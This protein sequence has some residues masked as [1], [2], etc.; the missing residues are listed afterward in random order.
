MNYRK[1]SYTI[2]VCVD[3]KDKQYMLIH[4]YTGAI[5]LVSEQLLI[6]LNSFSNENEF[7]PD[8]F[9]TLLKRGYLTEKTEDEERDYLKRMAMALFKRDTF[10]RKG[11]TFLVTYNCNFCCPYC[12]EKEIANEKAVFTKEMV[13]KAYHAIMQI[14]SEEK[15][16]SKGITLYGGEPLL[17]SNKKIVSYIIERGKEFGFTFSAI[18]N[19][20]DL[21]YYED[22]LSEDAIRFLQIT[23]DGIKERHNGRRV[24]RDGFS[25]FDKIVNNIGIALNKGVRVSV[26]VNTDRNNVNDLEELQALFTKMNYM[27]NELFSINTAL[28]KNYSKDTVNAYQYFS[29]KDFIEWNKEHPL[30]ISCQD[31][32]AYMRIYSAI[33]NKQPLSFRSTFCSAQTTGFVLDP[34]GNIYTCWE[35]VNQEKH[36]VGNYA[37][38]DTINWN[39]EV[40]DTWRNVYISDNPACSVCKYALLCGGG[41]PSQNLNIHHCIQMEDIVQYAAVKAFQSIN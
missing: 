30:K 3:E 38:S 28:L 40:L 13:D 4:G 41:C 7:E 22:L 35:V 19:G 11:F 26:R 20:Y 9:Q 36:C 21:E 5:D 14:A 2:T 6:T 1:S 34:L 15:L 8:V 27:D 24:H 39:T 25:T 12:F 16:R 10:S 29:E 37:S 31:Y 32:G 17:R 33:K 23:V 18:T